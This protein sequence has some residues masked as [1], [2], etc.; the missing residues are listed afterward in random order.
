M[1]LLAFAG[2][3]LLILN[4]IQNLDGQAVAADDEELAEKI[5]R[6]SVV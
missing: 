5:D 1:A 2:L 4:I 3:S 6:K